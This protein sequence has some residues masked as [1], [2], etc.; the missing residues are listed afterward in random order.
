MRLSDKLRFLRKTEGSLRG[1]ERGLTQGELVHALREH[2]GETL[3]QSYLSQIESGARPHLTN[4]SRLLLARFFR[5]HPG[6][7]VDD[8]D[9]YHAELPPATHLSEERLDTWLVSAADRFRKDSELRQALLILAKH[10]NSR[11]CLVVLGNIL[12]AP[13][14]AEDLLQGLTSML[15]QE[16]GSVSQ[17]KSSRTNANNASTSHGD[18]R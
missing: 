5:V 6:Y 3:S 12:E 7:L 13:E 4:K 15:P 10:R 18:S 1:L 16:S 11:E 9:G 14:M 2:T 17:G 8:P